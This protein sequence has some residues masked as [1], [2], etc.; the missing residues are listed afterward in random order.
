MGQEEAVFE[1]TGAFDAGRLAG[2]CPSSFLEVI[3][4]KAMAKNT[5]RISMAMGVCGDRLT[6]GR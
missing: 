5:L 6:G 3:Q 2:A 4:R 1:L